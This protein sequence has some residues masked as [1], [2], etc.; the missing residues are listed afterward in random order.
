MATRLDG[1]LIA[2][3]IRSGLRERVGQIQKTTPEF[4]P[5]L[6]IVQVGNREDSNV[7][8]RKLTSP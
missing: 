6:A 1:K 8:I 2:A 7:Y 3:E 4:V 5:G